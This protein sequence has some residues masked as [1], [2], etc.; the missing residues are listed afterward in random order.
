[1]FSSPNTGLPRIAVIDYGLG[2]VRSIV[3]ALKKVGA[4]PELTN[5]AELIL[6][7][8]G[9]IIPGVGAFNAGMNKLR[10]Q[11]LIPAIREYADQGR[12]LMGICLGMQLLFEDS[13]EFG[14]T[15]GLGLIPG[16][17]IAMES[18]MTKQNKLP[19][20]SWNKVYRAEHQSWHGS[21]LD[22]L[23]DGFEAY[24]VHSFV[25]EPRFPAHSLATTIYGGANFCSATRLN[26]IQGFQFHPEKS[27]QDG[28]HII[29]SFVMQCTATNSSIHLTTHC[30]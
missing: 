4:K 27:A 20:I 8:D 10:R 12:P 22:G 25:A 7:C 17:V 16:H 23:D 28:L 5:S 18:K 30:E 14:Y 29:N 11:N 24:F 15:E 19:H 13:V 2:N 26:N 21:T 9:C 1:M 6:K 3:N